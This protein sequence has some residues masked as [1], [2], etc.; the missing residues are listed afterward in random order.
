MSPFGILLQFKF[1]SILNSFQSLRRRSKIEFLV[2]SAFILL[3]GAGLYFFFAQ[4]FGFFQ[5]QQPFGP[6]LLNE[7]L[8]LFTF[9]LFIMLV[10]SSSV[11]AYA[12]LFR[13]QEIPFLITQPVLWTEIYFLKLSEAVWYS[14][15]SVLFITVP[16]MAAYGAAKDILWGSFPLI[17]LIFFAPF[18]FLAGAFGTLLGTVTIWLLPGRK[19]RTWAF[20]VIGILLA[21]GF[22]KIQPHLVQ[23]QN[24][25]AGI[26]SGYLPNLKAAKHPMLPSFWLTEGILTFLRTEPLQ[27]F[28]WNDAW[29]YFLLLFSNAVFFV[30]PS[31]SAARWLYARAFFRSQDHG[32]VRKKRRALIFTS[33]EKAFDRLVWPSKPAMAFMEK[34]IKSFLRDPAEWSQMIIFFGLLLVYFSNLKNLQFDVLKDFWKN[35]VFV[36]NTVGVYIVLSSF[37]MRFVFPMLSLEGSKSWILGMAPIRFSSPLLVKLVLGQFASSVITLPLV[38][39]SGYMLGIPP[40]KIIY[41]TALGFFVC[42][43]LTGMSVGLGAM[44]PNFKSTNLSEIISG[45]GGSILL[46]LHLSYLT[47]IGIFLIMSQN[48][49]WLIFLTVAAM[50]LLIGMIPVKMGTHALQKMEF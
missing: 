24:S 7:I 10:I 34:D 20:L 40:D 26:L 50:S 12:T 38:F 21:V 15:W 13:S 16:F 44:F 28:S 8:Y 47:G 6:I 46:L 48:P 31:H 42:F 19:H 2:L 30:I 29:F 43:A 5:R 14:S 36:L 41:T 27:R 23:E 4:S 37:S 17:C 9:T 32:E 25:I 49:G 3:A 35:L 1:R 33:I 39:F 45:F 11:S 22:S 18:V